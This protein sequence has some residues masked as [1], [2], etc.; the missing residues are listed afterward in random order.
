M[1]TLANTPARWVLLQLVQ[2]YVVTALAMRLHVCTADAVCPSCCPLCSC[3]C[4]CYKRCISSVV[5]AD[6]AAAVSLY[7]VPVMLRQLLLSSLLLLATLTA[8]GS[9][10]VCEFEGDVS[11]HIRF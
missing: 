8:Y 10:A 7:C 4:C 5:P 2:H 3:C 6:A 9:P 11:I 1:T